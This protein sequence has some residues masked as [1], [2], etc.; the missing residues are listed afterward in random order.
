MS[1][2]TIITVRHDLATEPPR[3]TI[4][5]LRSVTLNIILC[6]VGEPAP[7]DVSSGGQFPA[8]DCAPALKT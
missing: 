5:T 6:G 2:R 3:R 8:N 4:I 7:I 1:G